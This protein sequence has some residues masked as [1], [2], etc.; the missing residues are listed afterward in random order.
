MTEIKGEVFLVSKYKKVAVEQVK[1]FHAKNEITELQKRIAK[2]ERHLLNAA[3]NLNDLPISDEW[4]GRW[5][6][7][8]LE[9]VITKHQQPEKEHG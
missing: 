7:K 4:A 9:L 2:L 3:D 8:T 5:A 6:E 1:L